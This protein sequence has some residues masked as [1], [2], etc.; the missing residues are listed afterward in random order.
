VLNDILHTLTEH[1]GDALRLAPPGWRRSYVDTA[2]L[3]QTDI[4]LDTIE[5]DSDGAIRTNFD[6]GDLD[7]LVLHITSRG[8]SVTIEK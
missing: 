2:A 7:L 6:F 8:R 4:W 5:L 1:V 3:D